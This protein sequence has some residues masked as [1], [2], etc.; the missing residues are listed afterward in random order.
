MIYIAASYEVG[1]TSYITANVLNG[2]ISLY[3]A[4]WLQLRIVLVTII[5]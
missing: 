1:D 3:A 2:N 5:F 4:V